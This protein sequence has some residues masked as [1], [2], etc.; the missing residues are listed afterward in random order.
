MSRQ[1][2]SIYN[3]GDSEL[4]RILGDLAA[5]LDVIEGL[6]PDLDPGFFEINASKD[7][8]TGNPVGGYQR[9]V[10][11]VTIIDNTIT[12]TEGLIEIYDPNGTLIHKME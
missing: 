11:N 9:V 6:R 4:D 1:T 12:V 7:I 8:T 2:R 5:R 10:N 3:T